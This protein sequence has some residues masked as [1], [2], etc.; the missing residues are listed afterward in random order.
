MVRTR[1]ISP[2][3]TSSAPGS[4]RK[5]PA[6]PLSI[7]V[8]QSPKKRRRAKAEKSDLE[9]WD[10]SENDII[11]ASKARWT[12]AVYDHYE[13]SLRRH[14]KADGSPNYLEFVFKCR[15]DPANHRPHHRK[16]M[17]TGQGTKNLKQGLIE[18]AA[19]RGVS[20]SGANSTGAQQTLT[21]S[22]SKYTAEAH[23]ALIALRCAVNK[24]PLG[25]DLLKWPSI[26]CLHLLLQLMPNVLSLVAASRLTIFNMV[27]APK[28]SKPRLLL[29]HGST[30]LLCLISRSPRTS[31]GRR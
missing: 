2:M 3:G 15:T 16:R 28:P 26:F 23:R 30:R 20:T 8:L 12:S 24:R 21:R 14:T 1:S 18:C 17:Q 4:P 22:V 25:L 9:V 7:P 27:L 31:C 10:E 11:E 29:D 13:T 5:R 19:R 6:S